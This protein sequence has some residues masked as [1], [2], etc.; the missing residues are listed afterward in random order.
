MLNVRYVIFR[1]SPPEGVHPDFSSPDYWVLINGNALPRVFVP[2]Q[3]ETISKP[4]QRRLAKLAAA[5]FDPRQTAYVEERVQL[6]APAAARRRSSPRFPRGSQF[7]ATWRPPGWWCWPIFGTRDGTPT[8][9]ESRSRSCPRITRS[10]ASSCPPARELLEFRYEPASLA[11]GWRLCGLAVVVLLGWAWW[12]RHFRLPQDKWPT[13]RRLCFSHPF[14]HAFPYVW[15]SKRW[16]DKCFMF[17][18]LGVRRG[19]LGP[20]RVL[21]NTFRFA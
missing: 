21:V 2:S 6:P 7:P 17:L 1:G 11:W 19:F 4:N 20:R 12:G 3:V 18:Q 10:A 8:G 13:I 5:D 9:K 16:V 15:L 14:Q